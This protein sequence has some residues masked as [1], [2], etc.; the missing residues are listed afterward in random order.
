[1]KLEKR[2]KRFM[3]TALMEGRLLAATQSRGCQ[4]GLGHAA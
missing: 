2:I 1:M 3:T 4:S